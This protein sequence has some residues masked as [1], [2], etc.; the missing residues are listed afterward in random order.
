MS[1][2]FASFACF[3]GNFRRYRRKGLNIKAAWYLAGLTLP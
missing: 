2:L 1:R 3:I